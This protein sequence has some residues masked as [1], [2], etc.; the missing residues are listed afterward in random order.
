MT[1]SN[2]RAKM[3]KIFNSSKIVTWVAYP[4]VLELDAR[5]RPPIYH[6][7]GVTGRPGARKRCSSVPIWG[8]GPWGDTPTLNN[9]VLPK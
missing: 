2:D 4:P 3:Y 1:I 9:P 8:R 6:Y 7:I 5:F